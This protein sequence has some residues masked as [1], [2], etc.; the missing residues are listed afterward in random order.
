MSTIAQT[1][2]DQDWIDQNVRAALAHEPQ[3]FADLLE[4]LNGE[5]PGDVLAA[6]R[7]VTVPSALIQSLL[8]NGATKAVTFEPA[9]QIAG[10]PLPHPCDFEWRFTRATATAVLTRVCD[11]TKPGEAILLVGMP[12]LVVAAMN[13]DINRHWNV[14]GTDDIVW[15]VLKELTSGDT[16]FSHDAPRPVRPATAAIV[17]PP[18]YPSAYIELFHAF[19]GSCAIGAQIFV[20]VPPA[21]ARPNAAVDVQRMIETGTDFG[22][23]FRSIERSALRY[24][25]PAF[26]LAALA[27][28]GLLA[29]L[30]EWRRGDLI[31]FEKVSEPKHGPATLSRRPAFEVTLGG[32]RIR[33]LPGDRDGPSALTP[34]SDS[35]VFN[36]VSMRAYGRERANLWTSGNRAFQVDPRLA[37]PALAALARDRGVP[38]NALNE[39]EKLIAL[40]DHSTTQ[41]LMRQ[42]HDLAATETAAVEQLVGSQSWLR[43]V[44]DARFLNSSPRAFLSMLDGDAGSAASS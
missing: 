21:G 6:L 44:N 22:L 15:S 30:P 18:W 9:D 42:F 20:G 28:A 10:L 8:A 5:Y 36:T 35:E 43:S 4:L 23:A 11:C 12:S 26:E 16:R 38:E 32:L 25:S 24:R 3:T 1:D 19:V 37:L 13:S 27:E 33:L 34:I 29:H 31:L 40:S 7:K 39:M 41:A 17:D 14:L 2:T